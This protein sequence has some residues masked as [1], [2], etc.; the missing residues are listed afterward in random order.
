[1][2]MMVGVFFWWGGGFHLYYF[3]SVYF[4]YAFDFGLLPHIILPLLFSQWILDVAV[5]NGLGIY[6]GL[7]TLKY[8]TMKTYHWRG[9]WR[10]PTYK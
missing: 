6:V 4:L 3:I 2:L 5:C 8:F 1:M 10:I 7:K 9:L